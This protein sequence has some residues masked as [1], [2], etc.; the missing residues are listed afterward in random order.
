MAKLDEFATIEEADR[1]LRILANTP[2]NWRRDAKIPV[3][4]NPVSGNR[5]AEHRVRP[6]R[7]AI[8]RHSSLTTRSVSP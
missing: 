2:R 4:R 1:F 3:Y 6:N 8:V 5:P 7:P